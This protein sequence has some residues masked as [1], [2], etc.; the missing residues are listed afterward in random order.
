[1]T[2]METKLWRTVKRKHT[3]GWNNGVPSNISLH[4]LSLHYYYYHDP[5]ALKMR[6]P[7]ASGKNN[8]SSGNKFRKGLW[9][10]EEDDKLMNYMLNNGQGIRSTLQES[11]Q[12]SVSTLMR[13]YWSFFKLLLM[14]EQ[15]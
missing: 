12:A 2:G 13:G 3:R 11:F 10:P 6:K 15:K 8:V 5:K 4:L 14:H 9:S 7:E 1:M